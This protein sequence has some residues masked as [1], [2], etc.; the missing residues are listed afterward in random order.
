MEDLCRRLSNNIKDSLG[1]EHVGVV[2][3]KDQNWE[4]K[5]SSIPKQMKSKF[6]LDLH[7]P[8]IQILTSH[9]SII[10]EE[11]LD[12][13]P[14]DKVEGIKKDL[15][16]LLAHMVTPIF[17]KENLIGFIYLGRKLNNDAFF[18]DDAHL[19]ETIAAQSSMAVENAS[20]F[21][22]ATTDGLTGLHHQKY[23][24][25]RLKK[26]FSRAKRHNR[27]IALILVD[28]DHFKAINDNLGHLAGDAV[29]RELSKIL[30]RCIRGED[31]VAR[32]GGEEFAALLFEPNKGSASDVGERIRQEVEK[33]QFSV[34]IKV[35]VSIGVYTFLPTHLVTDELQ[36]I[37]NAD[38]ALYSAKRSGR[39]RVLRFEDLQTSPELK[40]ISSRS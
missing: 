26:E 22:E 20:L 1:V 6:S 30:Q 5:Y 19:L 15:D 8:L 28:I 25:T 38:Q 9:K 37:E 18:E 7:S 16:K 36:L 3:F 35:T 27:S 11:I 33:Y 40:K 23:F 2:L 29:L 17:L 4:V 24:K 31:L 14:S 12:E 34:G 21:E 10:R 39:N 32:Y 13:V